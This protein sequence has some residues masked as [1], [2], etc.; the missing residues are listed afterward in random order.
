MVGLRGT[1]H[2]DMVDLSLVPERKTRGIFPSR[3]R[4]KGLCSQRTAECARK[5]PTRDFL[6]SNS[7]QDAE[8]LETTWRKPFDVLAESPSGPPT[9]NASRADSEGIFGRWRPL[10]DAARTLFLAPPSE[11]KAQMELLRGVPR[12]WVET[13]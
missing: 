10:V 7:F 13:R 2:D 6:H 3:A 1:P 9:K 4:E 8:R 11:V 12:G 5:A